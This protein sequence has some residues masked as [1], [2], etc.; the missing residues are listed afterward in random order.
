[1]QHLCLKT[2]DTH[3]GTMG[4]VI[5]RL[6]SHTVKL[7]PG[8]THASYTCNILQYIVYNLIFTI[9]FIIPR[10]THASYSYCNILQQSFNIYCNIYFYIILYLLLIIY[11]GKHTRH[12]V[13]AIVF[14]YIY[15]YAILYSLSIIYP[16]T[17]TRNTF[18]IY[19]PI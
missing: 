1:M 8:Q 3:F 10:Q 17:H 18:A 5:P 4:P 16:G 2:G 11:P 13:I 6:T 7:R 19:I 12:T 15:F 9:I 14:Q